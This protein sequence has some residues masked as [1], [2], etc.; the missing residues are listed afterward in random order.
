[1]ATI[2]SRQPVLSSVLM[3]DS[4]HTVENFNYQIVSFE[5]AADTTLAIGTVVVWDTTD[6]VF[7]V[8]LNADVASL[9]TTSSLANGAPIGVVVG[10]DS[11]GDAYDKEFVAATSGNVV[12]LFRGLASVKDAGL[13]LDAGVTAPNKAL[14]LK[15]LEKQDIAV[16]AASVA[17]SSDF[18]SASI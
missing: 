17:V 1:M 11:L 13:K 10:F 18:Y 6:S 3:Q 8:L 16:K 15:Q 5:E 14:V 4:F 7:R 12:V 2:S 9:P